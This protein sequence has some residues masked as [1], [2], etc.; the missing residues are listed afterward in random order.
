[1]INQNK[2]NKFLVST[3]LIVFLIGML[4][5]TF[6]TGAWFRDTKSTSGTITF[7][8]A[9][10]LAY[11]NMVSETEG[12]STLFLLPK[13]QTTTNDG[14]LADSVR[15]GDEVVFENPV[16]YAAVNSS[17]FYLRVKITYTGSKVTVGESDFD[18]INQGPVFSE[19]WGKGKESSDG[20]F[21]MYYKGSKAITGSDVDDFS[22]LEV[23]SYSAENLK[24]IKLFSSS[25]EDAYLGS[26][27]VLSD[28]ST[29]PDA[30][31]KI[32]IEFEALQATENAVVSQWFTV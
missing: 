26:K 1:M 7:A 25:A 22:E 9:V 12:G 17:D 18:L 20:S 21:Y 31:L 32:Q 4:C 30:D 27:I 28:F 15:P 8:N 10:T 23:V 16:V 6:I 11:E 14:I 19:E 3:L 24:K 29:K 5:F 13:G 2:R